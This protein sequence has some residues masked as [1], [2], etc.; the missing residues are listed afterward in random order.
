MFEAK[1]DLE[2][3]LSEQAR[4]GEAEHSRRV[5]SGV[6]ETLSSLNYLLSRPK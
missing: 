2:L 4:K 5:R 3:A 6:Q 1:R